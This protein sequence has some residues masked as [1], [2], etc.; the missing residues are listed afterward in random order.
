MQLFWKHVGT[1]F[2]FFLRDA[3][4][5][6]PTGICKG[7]QSAQVYQPYFVQE[8]RGCGE[9]PGCGKFW[10]SDS[11]T[12]GGLFYICVPSLTT[13][14][15]MPQMGFQTERFNVFFL[16]FSLRDF[17]KTR[18]SPWNPR[19]CAAGSKELLRAAWVWSCEK[20]RAGECAQSHGPTASWVNFG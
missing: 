10:V 13:T 12:S 4:S 16:V 9:I 1:F 5:A 17:G 15:R 11:A 14:W 7:R 18:S 19:Q 20:L 2:I 3:S 6:K 8:Q